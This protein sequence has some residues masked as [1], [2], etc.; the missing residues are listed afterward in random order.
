[1][2]VAIVGG[3]ISGLAA[4]WQAHKEGYDFKVF[5]ASPKFGGLLSTEYLDDDVVLEGGAESCL[6]SKPE[7]LELCKELGLEDEIIST[8]PENAGA[9]VVRLSLIHI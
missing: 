5:E 6:R 8:M 4:A 2:K 1:M 7:L 9:Y 3:G